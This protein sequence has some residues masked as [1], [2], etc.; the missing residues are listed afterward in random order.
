MPFSAGLSVFFR[1][2]SL[3][4]SLLFIF[5][6]R[7]VYQLVKVQHR[8]GYQDKI[9][10]VRWAIS[11]TGSDSFSLDVLGSCFRYN[12]Y[13]YLFYAFGKE[14][15]KSYVDANFTHLYDKPPSYQHPKSTTK[16]QYHRPEYAPPPSPTA[17]HS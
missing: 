17:Q 15:D 1:Q 16:K 6:T 10:A 9:K 14:P 5:C 8:F 3:V 7:R 13:R 11:T 4:S 12:G 2:E